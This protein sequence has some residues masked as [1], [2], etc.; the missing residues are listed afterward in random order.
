MMVFVNC[1]LSKQLSN[2]LNLIADSNLV[3]EKQSVRHLAD[4]PWSIFVF[5]RTIPL[6]AQ[7]VLRVEFRTVHTN[8]NFLL[9]FEENIIVVV[10][11]RIL[12]H[13]KQS[14][15]FEIR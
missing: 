3:A 1:K 8:M 7:S 15:K 2:H 9:V 11:S 14:F 12:N 5:P 4:I 10:L 6:I 13:R